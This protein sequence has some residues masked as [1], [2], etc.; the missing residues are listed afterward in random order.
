[1][2]TLLAA[3]VLVFLG[4]LGARWGFRAERAP[5]PMRLL[6]S[7]GTHFLLLGFLLG[8]HGV[9]LFGSGLVEAFSPAIVLGLGW[10]GLMF[11]MQ[12]D[13]DAMRA[14]RPAEIAAATT[15]AAVAFGLLALVGGVLVVWMPEADGQ[16]LIL[17]LSA[18]AIAAISTPTGLGI[19]FGSA[20]FRGEISRLLSVASSLDGAVG[21]TALALV[22]AAFHA[23]VPGGFSPPVLRWLTISVLLGVFAGWVLVSLIRVRPRRAE[24]VLFLI[25]L[26][27]LAAGTQAYFQ[28][29]A[30]FGS[31]VAG[32]FV[33]RAEPA[34]RRLQ[35]ALTLWEKPVHIVFLLLS[36]ALL[37]WPGWEVVPLV[38]LYVALRAG[39][40][41]VG[42]LVILPSLPAGRRPRTLGLGLLAQGGLS[43]A[44]AV[45]IRHVFASSGGRA[46]DLF[47]ATVV[48]GV[49]LSEVLGPPIIRRLLAGE[50]ELAAGAPAV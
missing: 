39:A 1:V 27:L 50:G 38:L 33:A 16:A 15:Q 2:K 45:S 10:I 32:L 30:L 13:A 28:L 31:A 3:L 22:L 18:A 44:M 43:I 49:A 11:G 41:L 29:S 40:K 5:L 14:V 37:R 34:R 47:F 26:G 21:L 35:D 42:G 9:G 24:L 7:T 12:F 8:P 46:L 23:A 17:V 6:L 19:V 25:A 4:L 20:P 36:G 48:L